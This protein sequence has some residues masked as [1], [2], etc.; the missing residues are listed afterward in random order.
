MAVNLSLAE[1]LKATETNIKEN[2]GVNDPT[3]YSK[4]LGF[5]KYLF[6]AGNKRTISTKMGD[7]GN[8][9]KYRPVEV[10][11]LPKKGQDGVSED[12]GDYTCDRGTTRR[13]SIQTLNPSLYAQDTFTLDEAIVREGTQEQL[14]SRIQREMKDAMLNTRENIDKQ[15]FA[16]AAGL[17]GANPAQGAGIGAYTTLEMLN[18]DGTL[19][20]DNFD[21]IV[22][23]AQDN[24]MIGDPGLVGSYN[25]RKVVNRLNVGDVAAGGINFGGVST[26]F[27]MDFYN[28]SYTATVHGSSEK[29]RVLAMYPGLQQY[30]QYN[31]YRG[32][33]YDDKSGVSIKT[34][35]PDPVFPGITYDVHLK[36]NDGCGTSNPQG[37]LT[38]IVFVYFDLW[39]P[40]QEAFGEGYT[41]NLNDFTGIVGYDITQA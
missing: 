24:F 11:Y 3:M 9:G 13:E 30:Y 37:F 17:V 32:G 2:V 41:E 7:A 35:M 23:D 38:G 26:Q 12:G 19:D 29:D 21:T 22:N 1:A 14:N 36:H 33:I 40:P 8:N 34:T 39:T 25:I 18:A 27:G 20:A 10:R 31:Y 6:G 28:D 5:S 15:L 16:A 4:D